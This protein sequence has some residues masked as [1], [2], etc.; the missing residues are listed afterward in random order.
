MLDESGQKGELVECV[1]VPSE[2]K[3]ACKEIRWSPDGKGLILMD[4]DMF[5]AAFEVIE[6]EDVSSA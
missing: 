6:V 1:S 4:K 3:F 2:K 5:C